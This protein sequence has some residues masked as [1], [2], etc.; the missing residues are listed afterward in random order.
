M[1]TINTIMGEFTPDRY[2]KLKV[3]YEDAVRRNSPDFIEDWQGRKVEWITNFAKYM[4]EF[5]NGIFPAKT[6]KN[7]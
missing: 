7:I 3:L 4:I 1:K 2:K 5:L 6:K